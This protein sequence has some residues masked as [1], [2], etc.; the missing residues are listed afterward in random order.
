MNIFCYC[1]SQS[2]YYPAEIAI[3]QF[4][5]DEGVTP[6]NVFHRII[7]P[8]MFIL[9]MFSC[10]CMIFPLNTFSGPLP[11][12][13]ACDATIHSKETHQIAPPMTGDTEYNMDEV[14]YE[15]TQ[16]LYVSKQLTFS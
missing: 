10:S 2:R 4:S 13:Y 1:S 8:G 9:L 6:E 12:G 7:K 16:F 3:V 5:L 15:M 14:Y 11:L